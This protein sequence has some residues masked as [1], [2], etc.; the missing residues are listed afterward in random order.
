MEYLFF[1]ALP[2]LAFLG[3]YTSRK[4]KVSNKFIIIP[5]LVSFA[6]GWA[7]ILFAKFTTMSLAVAQVIFDTS[8]VLSYFFAFVL[9]GE[10]VTWLQGAGVG[11]AVVG[12][13]LLSV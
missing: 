1:L 3:A 7:W 10:S 13:V 4:T 2:G 12:I 5:P 9:L 11:L 8:Y 6:V